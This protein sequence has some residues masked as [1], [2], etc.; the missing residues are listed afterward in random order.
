MSLIMPKEEEVD[1]AASK[2]VIKGMGQTHI[3]GMEKKEVF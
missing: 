1:N 2:S 3:C